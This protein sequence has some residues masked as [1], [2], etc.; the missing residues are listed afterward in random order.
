[1]Q[2]DRRHFP[3]FVV[4]PLDECE[5]LSHLLADPCCQLRSGKNHAYEQDIFYSLC[6]QICKLKCISYAVD[7][8]DGDEGEKPGISQVDDIL[9]INHKKFNASKKESSTLHSQHKT[10]SCYVLLLLLLMVCC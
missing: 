4:V 9:Y 7:E 6:T 10:S 8:G 5:L 2:Y 1:M 3:P